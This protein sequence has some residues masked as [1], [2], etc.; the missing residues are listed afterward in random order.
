MDERTGADLSSAFIGSKQ[1][2][3]HTLSNTKWAFTRFNGRA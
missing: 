2:I 1:Q 3:G